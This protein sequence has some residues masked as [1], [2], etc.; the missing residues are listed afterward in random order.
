MRSESTFGPSTASS[1][2]RTV[3]AADHR[4]QHGRH[5]A[6]PHR[7]QEHLREEQQRAER[8]RDGQAGERHGAPGRRHR[9]HQS[10]LGVLAGAELLAEP[11]HD[12]QRVVDREAET[13]HRDD[14]DRED[15]HVREQAEHPQH[16]EGTEDGESADRERQAGR[17]Q[18]AEDDDEQDEQ[19]RHRERLGAGDVL[20]DLGGDVAG[21]RL[22][23]AEPD[24][25]PRRGLAQDRLELLVRL[26]QGVVVRADE[27]QDGV[28]RRA[29]VGHEP[30]GV[31]PRRPVRRRGRH[32]VGRQVGQVLLDGCPEGRVADRAAAVA[33]EDDD[34]GRTTPD[35]V[36]GAGLR[37]GR[38]AARGVEAAGDHRAEDPGPPDGAE[39]EEEAGEREDET[40]AAVGDVSEPVEHGELP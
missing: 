33:V 20:A 22:V 17:G 36:L 19:D 10:R 31:R 26:H 18:A 15:R 11:R 32:Q 5:A 28:R 6:E 24:V 39:G 2:G 25:Q 27:L 30:S 21:D 7:A 38:L 14:V 35:G 12:E 29:V 37:A 4:H 9:G 13:Q 3:S 16:G 40:A 23:A 8:D 1:A 34:V